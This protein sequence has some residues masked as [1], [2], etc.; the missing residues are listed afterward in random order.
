MEKEFEEITPEAKVS[1][2][3]L[4]GGLLLLGLASVVGLG[5]GIFAANITVG[6]NDQIEFGTGTALISTCVD[7][8]DID[9]TTVFVPGVSPAFELGDVQLTQIVNTCDPSSTTLTVDVIN[10]AGASLISSTP[11]HTITSTADA[12]NFDLSAENVDSDD[13]S[14]ILVETGSN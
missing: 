2:K 4:K 6:T 13:I 5:A 3:K 14:Y 9:L 8:V 11:S 10:T 12:V 1:K 7:S